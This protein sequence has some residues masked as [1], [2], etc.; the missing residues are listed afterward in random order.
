MKTEQGKEKGH[1]V[2]LTHWDR[3]WHIPVWEQRRWLVNMMDTLLDVLDRE[4]GFR[5]YLLDGQT[6]PVEDYLEI[7][8]ENRDRIVTYVREGRIFIGPWFTLPDEFPVDGECLVRNLLWGRRAAD[9]LGG[10]MNIGLTTFGWGQTAQF[11][12]IYAGFGID[13]IITAKGVNAKRA[14]ESEFFWKS[15]DGTAA[16]TTRFGDHG[17]ANFFFHASL[18]IL[19]GLDYLKTWR[20][21]WGEA[22]ACFHRADSAG[23]WQDYIRITAPESFHPEMT[24][25]AIDEVWN[26]TRTTQVKGHRFLGNGSDF[27]IPDTRV[28]KII[29]EANAIFTDRELVHSTLPEYVAAMKAGID[30]G[31]LRTIEGELRDGPPEATS[32]NALA[33][34]PHIKRKNRRAQDLLI[35]CA[36]PL[37]TMAMLAGAAYPAAFLNQAW[38]FLLLSHPHDSINGVTQ[39]K[40]AGD[41]QNRLEQVVEISDMVSDMS[42]QEILKRADLSRYGPDDVLA[43]VFNPLPFARREIVKAWID[44]PQEWDAIDFTAEDTEGK[45]LDVQLVSRN[46][47]TVPVR[48]PKARPRPLYVDRHMVMMD[49]GNVP[50]C[51]YAVIRVI[52]GR[53]HPRNAR[54]WFP[55]E[56]FRGASLLVEPNVLENEHLRVRANPNGSIDVSD[57]DSGTVHE[58]MHFFESSGD[59]GD[60][61]VRYRPGQDSTV[62]SLGASAWISSVECGPLSATMITEVTM[63]VPVKAEKEAN[64]RSDQLCDLTIRSEL[65]L[66]RGSRSVEIRTTFTNTAED[67]RLRVLFPSDIPARFSDADGHF[68]VDRRPVDFQEHLVNGQ[69]PGMWPHPQQSFIDVSDGT[70]GLAVINDG[71]CE[72]EVMNNTRRIVALTLLRAVRNVICSEFRAATA[73]PHEKGGQSLVAHEFRYALC[74]H[75]GD[76]DKGGVI[77]ESRRF[78]VPVRLAQTG[79]HTGTLPVPGSFISIEPAQLVLAAMKKSENGNG[80]VMRLYNPTSRTVR[81]TVTLAARITKAG[82]VTMNEEEESNLAVS[83]GHTVAVEASAGKILTIEVE[84]LR[85]ES[86]ST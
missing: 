23:H 37:A 16:L 41:V 4:P 77:R 75:D 35:R 21:R 8:P 38:R 76:W 15:P 57:K 78:N 50:A 14:P 19:S 52:P 30:A 13:T 59:I 65:T 45:P 36:E 70:H 42:L 27:T 73:F 10:C 60:Y 81:G 53:K 69:W 61:W 49:T 55:P 82:L 24:K 11:P 1:V 85:G 62:T 3:E 71:I 29:D 6:I 74:F 86:R 7:K 5:G 63:R 25:E 64:R 33:I 79:S 66:K 26:S 31:K 83:G 28:L 12:Q 47:E 20:F 17:R 22:G 54:F 9:Q 58:G 46:E 48:D 2:C 43:A 39:D 68:N 67:H 32:C 44:T 56:E 51:G 18:P 72:Y 84:F 34:R 40:T 80:C